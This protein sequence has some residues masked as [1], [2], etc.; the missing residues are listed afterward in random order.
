MNYDVY[1]SL[2]VMCGLKCVLCFRHSN[3]ATPEIGVC[4]TQEPYPYS[5]ALDALLASVPNTS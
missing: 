3:V 2:G 5:E 1:A 4:L